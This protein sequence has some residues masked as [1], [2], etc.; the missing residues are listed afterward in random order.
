V[1]APTNHED[2]AQW[3][4]GHALNVLENNLHWSWAQGFVFLALE[5]YA[6][7]ADG[8][9]KP[10]LYHLGNDENLMKIRLQVPDGARL[11][12]CE[13]VFHVDRIWNG[14]HKIVPTDAGF[15][16]SPAGDKLASQLARNIEAAF[17]LRKRE[18]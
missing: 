15:T 18:P 10:F 17:E 1:P 11:A 12:D 2:P 16:H 5:G 8:R 13:I 7:T 3:P 14:E 9:R 4:A 6:N